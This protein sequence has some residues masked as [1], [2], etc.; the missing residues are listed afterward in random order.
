MNL[1][2][3]THSAMNS[4][5]ILILSLG[6]IRKESDT[7]EWLNWTEKSHRASLV[8]QQLRICF[9]C[10]RRGKT[11][12]QPLGQED[13]LEEEVATHSSIL[14]GESHGQR[15][16]VGYSP[17]SCKRIRQDWVTKQQQKSRGWWNGLGWCLGLGVKWGSGCRVWGEWDWKPSQQDACG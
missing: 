9:Q 10:R 15:S 2:A 3:L 17:W 7:T 4:V 5:G 6:K 14:A 8:A 13:P 12:V 16:L 1:I 11:W